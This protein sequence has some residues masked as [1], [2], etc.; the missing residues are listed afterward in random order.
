MAAIGL[1]S[2]DTQSTLTTVA[3]IHYETVPP[4]RT[5]GGLAAAPHLAAKYKRLRPQAEWRKMSRADMSDVLAAAQRSGADGDLGCV[6]IARSR[7][8]KSEIWG[9]GRADSVTQPFGLP[10]SRE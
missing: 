5:D 1:A 7:L 9:T 10:I 3:D 6:D 2:P 4:A 8:S